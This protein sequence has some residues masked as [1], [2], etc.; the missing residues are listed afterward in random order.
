MQD[1]FLKRH[2]NISILIGAVLVI[3]GIFLMFQQEEF[4][5][6]FISLLGIFLVISGVSNLS[7]LRR[8]TLG[9]RS[10]TVTII[11]AIVSVVV[12]VI[13]VILPY[14]TATVSWT[15]LLYIIAAQL[16]ISSVVSFFDAVM[17]RKAD[18]SVSFLY[19]EGIASLVIAVLLFVFPQQIGSM[20][21]KIVG[22]LLIFSGGAMAFWSVRIK[23]INKQFQAET[24][25]AEAEIIQTDN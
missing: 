9:K 24:I 14:S 16:V 21:L 4:V 15:V 20:L 3:L 6:I 13:A 1:T 11:K 8:L 10:K 23:K 22:L 19:S 25:E 12:G 5:K 7:S 17:M 2:L 18:F